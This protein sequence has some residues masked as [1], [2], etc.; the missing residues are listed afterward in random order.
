MRKAFG[1]G[2]LL[3]LLGVVVLGPV[4]VYAAEPCVGTGQ[5]QT[6]D[7]DGPDEPDGTNNQNGTQG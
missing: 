5:D 6:G 4:A 3:A 2:M 1:I 7:C